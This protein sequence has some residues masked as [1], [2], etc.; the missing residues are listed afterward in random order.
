MVENWYFI[1]ITTKKTLMRLVPIGG[2]FIFGHVVMNFKVG[3]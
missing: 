3:I 1:I 2:F